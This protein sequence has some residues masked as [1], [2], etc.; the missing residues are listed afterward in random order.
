MVSAN[1]EL[2]IKIFK[3]ECLGIHAFENGK[4]RTPA[5]DADFINSGILSGLK[6]GTG[7]APKILA[8]WLNGWDS[9]NSI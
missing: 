4:T 8:A 9:R 2:A 7:Q 1:E 3:A 6:I 5:L